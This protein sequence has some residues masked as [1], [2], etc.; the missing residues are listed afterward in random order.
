LGGSDRTPESFVWGLLVGSAVAVAVAAWR[1]ER[2]GM[3]F[4]WNTPWRHRSLPPLIRRTWPLTLLSLAFAAERVLPGLA[5][6][7]A[8]DGAVGV[9][10]GARAVAI[11][12]VGIGTVAAG[13]GGIEPEAST[14]ADNRWFR[15]LVTSILLKTV[16]IATFATALIVGLARPFVAT[17]FGYGAIDEPGIEA[18][19][20]SL[21]WFGVGIAPMSLAAVYLRAQARSGQV[22][23]GGWAGLV[24]S[25]L[26][27][28]ALSGLL[29]SMGSTGVGIGWLVW[30]LIAAAVSGVW[31]HRAG[32]ADEL[33]GV[34]RHV[35][36]S[37]VAAAAAGGVATVL[38]AVTTSI[39]GQVVVVVGGVVSFLVWR[40]VLRL[41][42]ASITARSR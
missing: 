7:F 33:T 36:G 2:A 19:A 25:A 4:E 1:F 12:A 31:W 32:T 27:V 18:I 40:A 5:G 29:D 41:V 9:L 42:G 13:L 24:A 6:Q 21:I 17:I 34:T 35:A 30:C 11:A 20:T 10:T 8:G 22:H 28:P 26:A 39:P 37:L 38:A 16:T 23:R 14:T 3:T 15:A